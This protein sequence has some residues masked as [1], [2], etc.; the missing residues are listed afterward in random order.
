MHI[1]NTK[2]KKTKQNKKNTKTKITKKNN[3]NKYIHTLKLTEE[4]NDFKKFC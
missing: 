3:N 4:E 1:K 2:Q